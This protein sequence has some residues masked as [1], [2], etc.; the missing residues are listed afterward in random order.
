MS[1]GLTDSPVNQP[2]AIVPEDQEIVIEE[3]A[4][5]PII[6]EDAPVQGA[7]QAIAPKKKTA[8]ERINELTYQKREAQ[9]ENL[10]LHNRLLL[11]EQDKKR[12]D[13]TEKLDAI[14]LKREKAVEDGDYKEINKIDREIHAMG[15]FGPSAA[16]V[17]NPVPPNFDPVGY[18]SARNSWYGQDQVMTAYANSLDTM[19]RNDAYWNSRPPQERLDEVARRAQQEMSMRSPQS[20][21]I[22]RGGVEG[23]SQARPTQRNQISITAQEMAAVAR[24]NPGLSVEEVRTRTALLKKNSI[25]NQKQR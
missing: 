22:V 10:E 5:E 7:A 18:F 12:K 24:M 6:V 2:Q 8:Q 14:Y 13:D 1:N 11:L 23:S 3:S 9:R 15:N 19:L 17:S 21:P 25:I 4:D 16:P 20:Q